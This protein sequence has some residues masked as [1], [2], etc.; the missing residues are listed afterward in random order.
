MS[1]TVREL[2]SFGCAKREGPHDD[3]RPVP[4]KTEVETLP[5]GLRSSVGGIT[6]VPDSVVRQPK[7]FQAEFP[8]GQQLSQTSSYN[9]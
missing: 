2:S 7:G 4:R 6:F 3:P 1:P 5:G 9:C 8:L